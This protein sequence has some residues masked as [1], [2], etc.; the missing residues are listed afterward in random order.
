VRNI[1]TVDDD[2]NEQEARFKE[3]EIF[4]D[5]LHDSAVKYRDALLGK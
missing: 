3:L 2:F 4:T 5:K 1:E